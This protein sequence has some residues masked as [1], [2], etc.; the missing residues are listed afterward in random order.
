MKKIT[1]DILNLDGKTAILTGSAG[2]IG[3]QFSH[4]L[5]AAGANVILVDVEEQKN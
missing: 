4:A 1:P 2:R 5:S 3:H